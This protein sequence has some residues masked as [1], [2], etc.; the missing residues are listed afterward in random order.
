MQFVD[1]HRSSRWAVLSRKFRERHPLCESQEKFGQDRRLWGCGA[2]GRTT[3][4]T[5][6]D[7]INPKGDRWNEDNLQAICTRCHER[8]TLSEFGKPIV[9]LDSRGRR[10]R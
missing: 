8:K 5:Q 4:A 10:I 7:H 2:A 6:V 3:K 1:F 9:E